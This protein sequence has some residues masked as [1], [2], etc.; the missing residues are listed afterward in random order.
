MRKKKFSIEQ[1]NTYF[2]TR[3]MNKADNENFTL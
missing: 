2:K 3:M 1:S